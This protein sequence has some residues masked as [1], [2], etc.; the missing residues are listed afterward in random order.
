[1]R[2]CICTNKFAHSAPG[3]IKLLDHSNDDSVYSPIK[4]TGSRGLITFGVLGRKLSVINGGK[5]NKYT[6]ERHLLLLKAIFY[7]HVHMD[8]CERAGLNGKSC[9]ERQEKFS[10]KYILQTNDYV[11]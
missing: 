1:M 4:T 8:A 3:I 7:N 11:K 10:E 6:S 9:A 2:L 5:H